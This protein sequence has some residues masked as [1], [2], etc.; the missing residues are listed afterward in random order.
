MLFSEVRPTKI[1]PGRDVWVGGSPLHRS[2]D[3]VVYKGLYYCLRCG[4]YATAVPKLLRHECAGVPKL[5]GRMLLK[6]LRDG[7]LPIG[8]QEWPN[9]VA[10]HS[11][12]FVQL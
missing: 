8:V 12:A 4:G 11:P 1:P 2:H 9:D 5:A 6:R 10:A 7:K 3:L